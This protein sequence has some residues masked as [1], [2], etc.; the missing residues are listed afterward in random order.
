MTTTHTSAGDGAAPRRSS[1]ERRERSEM[2]GFHPA[3]LAMSAPMPRP[4]SGEAEPPGT[5]PRDGQGK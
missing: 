3:I 1:E 2:F 5:S 4:L